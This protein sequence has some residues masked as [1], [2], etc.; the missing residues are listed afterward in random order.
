MSPWHEFKP[1]GAIYAIGNE[2]TPVPE[3]P[4]EYS[5]EA[6]DFVGLCLVRD[7]R[8]RLSASQLLGHIFLNK[9]VGIIDKSSVKTL[10]QGFDKNNPCSPRENSV[11]FIDK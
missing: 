9:K 8:Q 1:L 11:K 2:K 7:P 3:L 4:A 6:R 10:N 5:Q